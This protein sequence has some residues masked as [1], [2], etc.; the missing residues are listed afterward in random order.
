MTDISAGQRN[1]CFTEI[2]PHRQNLLYGI[3]QPQN[4]TIII[5]MYVRTYVRTYARM[6][7]CS[8]ICVHMNAFYVC[9]I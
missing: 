7:V 3:F 9:S 5:C 4:T 2:G 1:R 8:C 6:Y